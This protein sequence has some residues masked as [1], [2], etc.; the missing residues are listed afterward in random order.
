MSLMALV[1]LSTSGTGPE[2]ELS[3]D[4]TFH[5]L[6]NSRR[7]TVLKVLHGRETMHKRE[8]AEQ[9]AAIEC[10]V[11]ADQLE[12]QERKRVVVSLTQNHFPKMED[13]NVIIVNHDKVSLGPCADQ[14]L[15]FLDV[16]TGFF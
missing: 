15:E 6:Q 13:Y 1:G 14:L 5:L 11:E 3:K 16:T 4:D 10:G 7:R 12:S 8:L 9:V 2:V